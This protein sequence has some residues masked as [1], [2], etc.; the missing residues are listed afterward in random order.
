MVMISFKLKMVIWMPLSKAM[1]ETTK[2]LA[3]LP[4]GTKSFTAETG[5]TKFG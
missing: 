4:L 3:A 2:L 1:E 5:M